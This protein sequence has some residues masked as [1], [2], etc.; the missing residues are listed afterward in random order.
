MKKYPRTIFVMFLIISAGFISGVLFIDGENRRAV[1]R[2]ESQS[3]NESLKLL[4]GML[5][6]VAQTF[7]YF[8]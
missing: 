2:H 5:S 7:G 6:I 1:V 8:E 3:K 4:W